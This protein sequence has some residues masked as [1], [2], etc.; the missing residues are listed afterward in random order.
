MSLGV[1]ERK[2]RG[3]CRPSASGEEQ[4]GALRWGGWRAWV[5][6]VML[7]LWGG[8]PSGKAEQYLTVEEVLAICF[9]G[10]ETFQAKEHRLTDVEVDQIEKSAGVKVRNRL[11]KFWSAHAGGKAV[12]VLILDQVYGKHELIDYA[13]ALTPE[14]AVKQVEV[15]AYRERYGSEVRQA[16]W[17]LQFAGKRAGAEFKLNNDIYNI[18]G[19]TIS[20]RRVAEGIK[21]V[22]ATHEVLGTVLVSSG[23]L[24]DSAALSRR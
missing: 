18:S 2:E 15:M 20:C 3:A 7:L 9:S 12:G 4:A 13:V 6:G 24:P 21:R 1:D 22:V 16:K 11:V 17:R 14:G 19:A 10:A 5:A 8:L 23:R